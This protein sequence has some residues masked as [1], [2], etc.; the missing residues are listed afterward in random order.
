MQSAFPSTYT[1]THIVFSCNSTHLNVSLEVKFVHFGLFTGCSAQSPHTPIKSE[2]PGSRPLYCGVY[3]GG[4][5]A[6]SASSD[7]V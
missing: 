7:I 2:L 6:F 1:Y 3:W 5:K 4:E